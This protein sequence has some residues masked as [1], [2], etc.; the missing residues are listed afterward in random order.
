LPNIEK[1][2][3]TPQ[4]GEATYATKLTVEEF[5]VDPAAS[6]TD[7]AL[8]VRA[9]NPRPGAWA[10]VGRRRVK[11]LRAHVQ[12]ASRPSQVPPSATLPPVGVI[13]PDAGLVTGDG[14][15]VLDE[16]QP[17]G[18]AAMSGAAWL[19]GWRSADDAPQPVVERL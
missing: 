4:V 7:L 15:L 16:V 6:A 2:T 10:L 12:A 9:G 3:P 11:V 18:K 13:T 19:A 1:S 8:L 14:I 5:R 17:E